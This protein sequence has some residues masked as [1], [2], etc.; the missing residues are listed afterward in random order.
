MSLFKIASCELQYAPSKLLKNMF[1]LG[2]CYNYAFLASTNVNKT[3]RVSPVLCNQWV[4]KVI[5]I[6]E[7]L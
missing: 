1:C 5:K 2:K 4:D 7:N 3:L 6:R